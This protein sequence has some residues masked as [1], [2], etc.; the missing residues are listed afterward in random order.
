MRLASVDD[1]EFILALRNLPHVKGKMGTLD[2]S[3]EQEKTWIAKML[4]DPCDYFFIIESMYSEKLGSIGVYNIRW[5]TLHAE[6]GRIV[7][8]PKSLAALPSWI[9]LHDFCFYTLKLKTLEAHTLPTNTAVVDL[10]KQLGYVP[11]EIIN[12]DINIYGKTFNSILMQIT[13]K[14]W[15][16]KRASLVTI[17]E[18]ALKWQVA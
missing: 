3:L 7:I 12:D 8:I 9:L 4:N 10:N 16:E 13:D 14:C 18:K 11:T 2:I 15:G 1:A 17:A 5:N 6:T